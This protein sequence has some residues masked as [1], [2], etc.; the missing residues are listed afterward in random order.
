MAKYRVTYYECY[1]REYEVEANSPEEAEEKVEND[2]FEGKRPA[3]D[4]C[5]D[6]GSTSKKIK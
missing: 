5:Y 1:N 3:P 2:I 4:Y 6:S